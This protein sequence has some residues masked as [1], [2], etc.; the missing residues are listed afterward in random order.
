MRT[1]IGWRRRRSVGLNKRT[2]GRLRAAEGRDRPEWYRRG[3]EPS[4]GRARDRRRERDGRPPVTPGASRIASAIGAPNT[5]T[6]GPGDPPR[7][8]CGLGRPRRCRAPPIAGRPARPTPRRRAQRCRRG[9]RARGRRACRG[10][11]WPPRASR[12]RTRRN[13]PA[14]TGSPSS[15]PTRC[16]GPPAPPAAARLAQQQGDRARVEHPVDEVVRVV[17]PVDRVV[18]AE[19]VPGH[20]DEERQRPIED[21]GH[22]P[23]SRIGRPPR[24]DGPTP[25]GS[26]SS[27][28]G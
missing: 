2:P 17:P 25:T 27:A 10:P 21:V 8:R 3:R 15:T 1:G 7:I 11:P 18:Q 13:R 14:P 4:K 19:G 23:G 12:A 28:T 20:V 5:T 26:T 24:S 22:R 9:A 6:R 16:R